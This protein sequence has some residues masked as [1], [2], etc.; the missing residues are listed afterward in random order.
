[1]AQALL[2]R[3]GVAALYGTEAL[4]CPKTITQPRPPW[5]LVKDLKYA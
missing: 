5:G 1:M 3:D 4:G 2:N